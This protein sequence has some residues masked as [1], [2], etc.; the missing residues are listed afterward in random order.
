MLGLFTQQ[1]PMYGT[2]KSGQH[3]DQSIPLSH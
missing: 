2:T 1:P 3:V